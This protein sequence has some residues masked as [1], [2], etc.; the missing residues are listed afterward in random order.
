MDTHVSMC[1]CGHMRQQHPPRGQGA[2]G[3]VL[4]A[5]DCTCERFVYDG[6]LD[7]PWER[8]WVMG[9]AVTIALTTVGMV[10]GGMASDAAATPAVAPG[11]SLTSRVEWAVNFVVVAGFMALTSLV[12]AVAVLGEIRRSYRRRTRTAGP[13]VS[14]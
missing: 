4:E 5:A 13:S 14:R 1:R 8:D 3:D 9:I 12:T 10:A 11:E 2:C 7:R 6:W